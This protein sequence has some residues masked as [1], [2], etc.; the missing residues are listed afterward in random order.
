MLCLNRVSAKNHVAA[1]LFLDFYDEVK[2]SDDCCKAVYFTKKNFEIKNTYNIKK[3][4]M[5]DSKVMD[6]RKVSR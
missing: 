3:Y 6:G 1:S 2:M 5:T 4:F